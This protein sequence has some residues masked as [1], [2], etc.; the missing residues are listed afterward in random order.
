MQQWLTAYGQCLA[1]VSER[2]SVCKTGVALQW[3]PHADY[4]MTPDQVFA[5]SAEVFSLS[6]SDVNSFKLT[7][8]RPNVNSA[9]NV[10][11]LQDSP[12]TCT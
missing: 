8:S 3:P 10:Q 1:A 11:G 7:C 9:T 12:L 2:I 6:P 4:H 5:L